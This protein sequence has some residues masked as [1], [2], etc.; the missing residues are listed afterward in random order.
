MKRATIA[1]WQ[2]V[3]PL[4]AQ[5]CAARAQSRMIARNR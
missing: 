5:A 2:K 3:Q 4:Y 1:Y